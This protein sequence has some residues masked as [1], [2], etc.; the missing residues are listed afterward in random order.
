M[1][2]VG[3]TL[4]PLAALFL[5]IFWGTEVCSA[6]EH[7]PSAGESLAD[8]SLDRVAE[9]R[10]RRFRMTYSLQEQRL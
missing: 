5:L 9:D 6:M 3:V 1:H 8:T 4:I 2:S 7:P 10:V